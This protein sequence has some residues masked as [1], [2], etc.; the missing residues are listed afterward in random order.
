MHLLGSTASVRVESEECA[1]RPAVAFGEQGHCQEDRRGSRGKSDANC[2]IAVDAEAPFQ[3][4]PDIVE[5]S[6]T[7]RP[8]LPLV[9]N[10]FE[11][12]AVVIG[13][14][15]RKLPQF[16]ALGQLRKRIGSCR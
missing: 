5:V 11:Q 3:G 7:R 2:K 8:L 14:M 16:S 4:R 10:S 15:P 6:A 1:F 12:L 9:L 13:M